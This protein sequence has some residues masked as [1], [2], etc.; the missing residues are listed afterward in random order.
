MKCS[1]VCAASFLRNIRDGIAIRR[2]YDMS[3][4][5]LNGDKE[6]MIQVVLN[7]ARNAAQA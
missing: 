6:Q 3:L 5:S 2:D 7:I 4:P 1:N